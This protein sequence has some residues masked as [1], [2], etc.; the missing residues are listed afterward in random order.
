MYE[1]RPESIKTYITDSSVKLPRFQRKQTWDDKKN[2]KLCI[3]IFK[4]YPIG[5]CIL[6]IEKENASTTKWL[7]DGRQRRNALMNLYNDPE[8]IYFWAQKF[9]GFKNNTQPQELEKLFWDKINEYLELELEEEQESIKLELF[10]E[11]EIEPEIE[12]DSI[13]EQPPANIDCNKL[14]GLKLLL[15]IIKLTHNRGKHCTGFSKPFDFSGM[16]ENLPY[17]D[18]SS[19]QYKLASKKIKSF[20]IQFKTHCSDNSIASN[21][22]DSFKEFMASRFSLDVAKKNKLFPKIEKN[23]DLICERI[24]IMDRID[25]LLM[26][27]KIGLIEVKGLSAVDSQKIFNI[28]NTEGTQLTAV[29]VSSAKPSWNIPIK[30]PSIKQQEETVNLYKKIGVNSIADVVKWDIPATFLRRLENSEILFKL[31]D[32][33]SHEKEVTLGFKILSGLFCSGVRREDIDTLSKIEINWENDIET[34]INDSNSMIKLISS[35]DYFKFFKSWKR[36]IASLLSEG[37]ALN[38]FLLLYKDFE[39]KGKPNGSETSVRAKQFQ[40]NAFILFDKLIYE[41]IMKEWR[42]SSDSKIAAN[43]AKI[44]KN[45][46]IF[47]HLEKEKWSELLI[48]IMDNNRLPDDSDLSQKMLEPILF[49]FYC[50]KKMSAPDSQYEY[51]VDHIFPQSLFKQSTRL[52][53]ESIQHN[54]YNLALLPKDGNAS[55]SSKKLDEITSD[56]LKDQIEKYSFIATHRFFH[57][58]DL[59]NLEDLKSLRKPIFLNSFDVERQK[60]LDN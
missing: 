41:Y 32:E 3:S 40:K 46:D 42:G 4:E 55:K 9:I 21:S 11:N 1:I 2:F 28:I 38:F 43:L 5:V 30:N 50:L 58:S 10:T 35:S 53:K 37:I 17:V 39:L 36:P 34:V 33:K 51:E 56:W 15:A 8:N 48:E 49:H 13:S 31:S 54:L 24:Q 25:A 12:I 45:R 26:D 27:S 16:I 52:D 57:F 47:E 14:S 29:E 7:L 6:N 20:I 59:G 22:M 18:N 23:W 60:I 44:D 19:G